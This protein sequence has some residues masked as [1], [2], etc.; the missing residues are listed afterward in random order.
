MDPQVT[1]KVDGAE[2]D[3]VLFAICCNGRPFTYY[4]RF[5]VD[6][7]PQ[8]S[9]DGGLDFMALTKVHMA[10]IPRIVWGVFV[11]RSHPNWRN[12]RY[13]HDVMGA[14]IE[15]DEAMPVQVDGDYIGEE[16]RVRIDLVPDA[17]DLLV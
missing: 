9:L 10:T 2:P 11:S 7:C 8:A 17:L 3:R 5:A 15:A 12:S 4:K 13:H 6:A 1:L 16:S 14:T